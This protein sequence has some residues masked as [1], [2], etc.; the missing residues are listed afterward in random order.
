MWWDGLA[1][2]SFEALKIRD[3]WVLG[4]IHGLLERLGGN[5]LQAPE[6]TLHKWER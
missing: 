5:A 4:D 2:F 6:F 1:M 3:L